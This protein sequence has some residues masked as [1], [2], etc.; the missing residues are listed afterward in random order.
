MIATNIKISTKPH[1]LLKMELNRD[2]SNKTYQTY[3]ATTLEDIMEEDIDFPDV[4]NGDCIR[5]YP[6]PALTC[7]VRVLSNI[8]DN[9]RSRQ[10]LIV[11]Y[12][13]SGKQPNIKPH[14][15]ERGHRRS[16]MSS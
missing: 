12:F 4:S 7:D 1:N 5:S 2:E 13:R 6:D 14:M 9:S 15:D 16:E 3:N 11:D 10:H 8:L